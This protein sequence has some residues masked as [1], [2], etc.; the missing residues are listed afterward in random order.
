MTGPAADARFGAADLGAI[1]H[2]LGLLTL[3]GTMLS[4]PVAWLVDRTLHGRLGLRARP[5]LM[6]SAT[7]AENAGVGP[8]STET[9]NIRPSLSYTMRLGPAHIGD[10]PPPVV[11]WYFAPVAGY[12]CT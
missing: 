2:T 7:G 3:A 10:R 1:G 11:I 9:E 6:G 12:G 5:A 8:S 4:L